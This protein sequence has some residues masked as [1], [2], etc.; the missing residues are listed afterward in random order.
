MGY[1]F[2]TAIINME[3]LHATEKNKRAS[4]LSR[5]MFSAFCVVRNFAFFKHV[6]AAGQTSVEPGSDTISLWTRARNK[7]SDLHHILK[8]YVAGV[9][10]LR[11]TDA[12]LTA[13]LN[14]RVQVT[15]SQEYEIY[16][17]VASVDEETGRT[18]A[19]FFFFNTFG[20]VVIYRGIYENEFVNPEVDVMVLDSMTTHV[21][22]ADCESYADSLAFELR[23]TDWL[24]K[25]IGA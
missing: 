2:E 23:L 6:G 18:M 9:Q 25:H 1:K 24:Q 20:N 16:A 15:H 4:P 12:F 3:Q 22:S 8:D 7:P 19:Y 13:A 5:R 17:A 10:G 14:Y 11:H 21:T